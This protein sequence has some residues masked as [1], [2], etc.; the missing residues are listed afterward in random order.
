MPMYYYSAEADVR[1]C[2][3]KKVLLEILRNS[4]ENTCAGVSFLIKSKAACSFTTKKT[5]AQMLKT[6]LKNWS[7]GRNWRRTCETNWACLLSIKVFGSELKAFL[8]QH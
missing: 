5:L 8:E 6:I 1:M 7:D 2:S 4:Q 3:V